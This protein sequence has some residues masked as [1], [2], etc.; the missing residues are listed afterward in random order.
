[1]S[2]WRVPSRVH[3]LLGVIVA[4]AVTASVPTLEVVLPAAA[5]SLAGCKSVVLTDKLSGPIPIGRK[6]D[7]KAETRC[8]A[9]LQYQLTLSYPDGSSS[10]PASWE[11]NAGR[12]WTDTAPGGPGIYSYLAQFR[13]GEHG[14]AFTSSTLY[15]IVKEKPIHLALAE[16]DT[17]LASQVFADCDTDTANCQ[18][19][20]LDAIDSARA[21]EHLSPLS[22]PAN[23]WSLPVDDQTL[24]L[25]DEERVSRHLA[26]FSGVTA[27]LATDA[28]GGANA[29]TDPT[30]PSSK[31][32]WAGNWAEG[33]NAAEDDFSY[34]FDDGYSTDPSTANLD[35]TPGNTTGCWGHRENILSDWTDDSGKALQ[36]GTACSPLSQPGY[37]ATYSCATLFVD[38]AAP[39]P[40]TYT[41]AQAVADG[42]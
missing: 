25:V 6:F 24:I 19:E 34:M 7:M 9:A 36:M 28:V 12:T 11:W 29:Q 13:V 32:N 35:C 39:Q 31:Y 2:S 42:A 14:P 22:I 38:S 10:S 15:F 18:N 41:W 26:P 40:Y 4:V 5:A 16:N 8:R 20:A 21:L 27:Q 17:A 3:L 37:Y 30:Y 23:F 33:V 1:M